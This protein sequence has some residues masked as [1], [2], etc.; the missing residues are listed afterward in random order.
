VENNR[1]AGRRRSH[2]A[3]WI[4]GFSG[5]VLA[6]WM[7]T[8]LVM[9]PSTAR[10]PYLVGAYYYTWYYQDHWASTDYVGRHLPMPLEPQLG[11]YVSDD[12]AVI[13]AHVKWAAEY[14]IDFFIISWSHPGSFADQTARKYLLPAI[15]QSNIRQAP[16]VE[17]LSY[18]ERDLANPE[19]R[20]RLATD[21]RY[22]GENFL[23]HPSALRIKGK[24]VLLL[25]VTRALLGDVASWIAEVRRMLAD[26]GVDPFIIADEVFWQDVD[27]ARLRAFDAV[28]AYNVYDWPRA[29]N[30][31]FAGDSTFLA[32]VEGLFA[33]WQKAAQKAGV[34]FVPNAMP[35]YNDRGVR[36]AENHYVIPRQ[37]K[38]TSPST[39]LLERSV[40]L[41]KRFVDPALPI[42]TITS[43]NEWHEWTQV[44]PARPASRPPPSDAASFTQ[45]FRHDAYS[46]EYLEVIR[47]HLGDA[48]QRST[49]K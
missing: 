37:L 14:G 30:A 41:A 4:L 25:Y 27:P 31:G 17:L 33:R 1:S 19:L 2:A 42:V 32:D 6:G 23:K 39:S 35:G 13:G 47:D 11:E 12:P 28:T 15:A 43:F 44:E 24:P 3:A 40:A 16:I 49:V 10:L 29:G 5:V 22:V 34:V 18:G 36:P 26:M 9:T 8:R 38:P 20:A 7:I 48:A 21:L 46:F 45:G